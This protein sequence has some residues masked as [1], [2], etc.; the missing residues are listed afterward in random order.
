M[1]RRATPVPRAIR[2]SLTELGEHVAAWRRLRHLTAEQVADRAGVSRGVV[3]RLESG[4]GISLENT[5]RIARALG[6]MDLILRALDPY[7]TDVGRL[8]ADEMLPRRV[9]HT[10]AVRSMEGR[11]DA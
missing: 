7:S 10:S 1:A 5:L 9:R 6:V 2:R 11:T 4:E 8:R 3:Q